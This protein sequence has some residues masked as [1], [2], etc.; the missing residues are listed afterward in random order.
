M[1]AAANSVSP[2]RNIRV[3]FAASPDVEA[4]VQLIN[5]AFVVERIAFDGDRIDTAGVS[6]LMKKGVFLMAEDAAGLAGCV[7][8]EV[9]EDRSYLG[10][11]S[12]VPS[13][14]GTGSG[15]QLVTAAE[16]FSRNAKCHTMD[17]RIISPRA[18]ELLP[19][20]K[21]L[22]YVETETAPFPANVHVKVPCHYIVM[23]KALA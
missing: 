15:R 14:Q 1:T 16:E 22:G 9:R 19:F 5:Q 17:L 7:Y 4:I 8:V 3:R 11:L 18:E 12:V 20:Y 21:H 23:A 2:E 6:D 13:R 10:L